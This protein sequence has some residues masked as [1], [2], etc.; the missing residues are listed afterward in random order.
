M[1]ESAAQALFIAGSSVFVVA[2]GAHALLTLVDAVRPTF[3]APIDRSVKADME[4]TGMRFRRPFPGDESRPSMW[5][6]WLGFNV[7]HGLGACAFGLLC[8]VISAYDFEL[9]E[10]IDAIRPLTIAVAAAYC[11]I[12][13]R[14][15]FN[16][17]ALMTGLATAAFVAAAVLSA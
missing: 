11:A 12:A 2:G 13:L 15:W 17:I 6:V 10:R 8:L 4:R 16:A 5:R 1:N 9:V 3:F 14:F 7:S